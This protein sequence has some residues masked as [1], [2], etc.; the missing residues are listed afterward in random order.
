MMKDVVIAFL[1]TSIF[2]ACND[3]KKAPDVSNIK[4]DLTVNRFEQDFFALDL[5]HLD[6]SLDSLYAKDPAFFQDF[7]SMVMAYEQTDTAIKYIPLFIR[8]SLYSKVY[9]DAQSQ[10]RSFDNTVSQI[11]KGLQYVKHY[12][13]QYNLPNGI[14]TFI[15]PI[16]GVATGITS[17]NR[18]AIGLQGYLGKDYPAY[19]TAYIRTVYP[20]YRSRKFE[21]EYITVNCMQSIIDEI[22]PARYAGKP[23]IEQMVEAGKRWYMLDQFLPQLDDSLKTGYTKA[24]LNNAYANESSIW[25]HFVTG[26]LLYSSDQGTVRDYM[27]DG[28]YT[29]PLGQGSPP[30]IGHFIGWQIVKKWMDKT[31]KTMEELLKMPAKQVFEEAK[32]KPT[33]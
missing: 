4:I 32:Y 19:H 12:F 20:E 10:F 5:D 8:D 15:G 14:V 13:P 17:N 23:L 25:G 11:K 2:V 21:P 26:N 31:G 6:S 18:F 22:Y 29:L 30:N 9:K 3:E 1:F 7:L 24:Q 16:D 28:P 33:R 27:N